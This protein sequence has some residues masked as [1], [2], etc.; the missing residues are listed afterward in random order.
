MISLVARGTLLSLGLVLA[1]AFAARPATAGIGF[2]T[3]PNCADPNTVSSHFTGSFGGSDRCEALCKTATAACRGAVKDA[4]TCMRHE[5]SSYYKAFGIVCSTLT[6][7]EKQNCVD[8]LKTG[9]AGYKQSVADQKASALD[10]CGAF[11]DSCIMGCA[12]PL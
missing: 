7:T 6:G 5:G 3:G 11:L 12:A 10:T 4:V 1:T 9:K 2:W 8:Q